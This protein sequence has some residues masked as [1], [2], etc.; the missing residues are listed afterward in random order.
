ME[1][2]GLCFNS[3]FTW[4]QS[5]WIQKLKICY[6]STFKDS[7]FWFFMNFCTFWRLKLIKYQNSES[8]VKIWVTENAKISK[9]NLTFKKN[10]TFTDLKALET[11][12][13]IEEGEKCCNC[14]PISS[15]A[16]KG[17][18]QMLDLGLF[19]DRIFILFVISNF[20][21][22]IGFNVPYVYTVVSK[23]TVWKIIFLK[24]RFCLK[25]N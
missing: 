6:F 25:S 3:D 1:I 5:W 9:T 18:N 8:Y 2:A 23:T 14:I 13:T 12:S 22:S 4:N 19:K 20:L 11:S 10:F 24:D 21:T 16:S 15:E 17:L 7:E